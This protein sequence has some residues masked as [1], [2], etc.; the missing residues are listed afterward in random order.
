[1]ATI[2]DALVV[3]LGIDARGFK[4]GEQE[5]ATAQ[6]RMRDDAERTSKSYQ[7]M[8]RHISTAINSTRNAALGLLA[9]FTAG[10]GI[11]A[12]VANTVESGSALGRLSRDLNISAQGITAWEGVSRRAGNA[13]GQLSSAFSAVQEQIQQ[14]R[15]YGGAPNATLRA[16]GVQLADAAGQ[17]RSLDDIYSDLLDKLHSRDPRERLALAQ[18]AGFGQETVNLAALP[19]AERA[20]ML[21]EQRGLGGGSLDN[22]QTARLNRLRDAWVRFEAAV[23]N[24]STRIFAD[25]SPSIQ[26]VVDKLVEFVNFL[27]G[28]DFRPT[29]T[30]LE[31]AI[32]NFATYLGSDEFIA[33]MRQLRDGIVSVAEAIVRALRWLGLIPDGSGSAGPAAPSAVPGGAPAAPTPS[34]QDTFLSRITGRTPEEQ[35]RMRLEREQRNAAPTPGPQGGVERRRR[36]D[37]EFAAEFG[38]AADRVAARLGVSREAVLAHWSLESNNGR[39]FAGQNNPGNMTALPSQDATVGA[40]RDAQGNPIS[41]R[42]RNFGSLDEFADSYASWVERRAPWAR[43][44]TDPRM[45]GQSLQAGGYATDPR[46]ADSLSGVARRFAAPPTPDPNLLPGAQRGAAARTG[47]RDGASLSTVETTINGPITVQTQATD[48]AGIARDLASALAGRAFTDQF[49]R[50]LA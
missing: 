26:M 38:P 47:G 19:A 28:P 27:G 8:G 43:G 10:Q 15:L 16:L 24:V 12:F 9:V 21:A 25:L 39:S 17:A 29:F 14:Q 11:R 34:V 3:T 33:S 5:N 30:R 2:I 40:D 45:Y 44:V 23:N 31:E 42:F 41:Q 22:E 4:R 18:G 7:E 1:M 13:A 32:R 46:F 6:K 37:A 36:T 49:T 20:R 50:G 35:M 48:A